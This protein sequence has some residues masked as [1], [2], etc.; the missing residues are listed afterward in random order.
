MKPGCRM[1]S[2]AAATDVLGVRLPLA[3]FLSPPKGLPQGASPIFFTI[4]AGAHLASSNVT[5]S[6]PLPGS[7]REV[8][9]L[10]PDSTSTALP[11]LRRQDIAA[12]PPSLRPTIARVLT[13][14]LRS[15]ATS[16]VK[17]SAQSSEPPSCLPLSQTTQ[18]LSATAWS[19]AL[20]GTSFN[21]KEARNQ[22]SCFAT[23]FFEPQI[24]NVSAEATAETRHRVSRQSRRVSMG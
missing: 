15:P 5:A 6:Q 1:S 18:W 22:T 7:A 8:F 4:E 2:S 20:A 17:A 11:A 9:Q 23:L 12:M 21:S 13:P 3:A 16:A 19:S 24:Q 10:A 14:T